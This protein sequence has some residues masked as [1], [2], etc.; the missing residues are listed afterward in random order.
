MVAACS[1]DETPAFRWVHTLLGDCITTRAAA[2][3][4][5]FGLM[6]LV[7]SFA[8]HAPQVVK[9]CRLHSASALSPW[10]LVRR[11]AFLHGNNTE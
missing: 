6:S 5:V 9:N 4:L 10:F 3:S 11:V 2:A 8:A 7:L 1:C